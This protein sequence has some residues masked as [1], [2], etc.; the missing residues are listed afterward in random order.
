[1]AGSTRQMAHR[2]TTGSRLTR[3]VVTQLNSVS[4]VGSMTRIA[5]EER[6]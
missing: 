4:S 6:T 5:R 2:T 3:S 1:M